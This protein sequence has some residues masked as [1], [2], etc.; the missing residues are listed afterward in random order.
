MSDLEASTILQRQRSFFLGNF[1]TFLLTNLLSDLA[2]LC[3]AV[4][5]YFKALS[6]LSQ[7]ERVS[8][9]FRLSF[10]LSLELIF[11]NGESHHEI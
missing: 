9:F 2:P 5:L 8:V 7:F 11:L 6:S 1:V 4:L 10:F 3:E